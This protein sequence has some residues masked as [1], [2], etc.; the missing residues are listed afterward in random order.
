[1]LDPTILAVTH[2]EAFLELLR[3]HLRECVG[4][5]ARL[6]VAKTI[7]DACSLLS[8]AQPRVI[9]LHWNR[10]GSHYEQ[11]DRL[12]WSTSVQARRIATV[13]IAERYRTEQATMM[14]R[15]G[16]SEYI[17]R[18]HHV[19]QIGQV[20]AAYIRP[21]TQSV[22]APVADIKSGARRAAKRDK[23]ERV[24]TAV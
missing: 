4:A 22:G 18:T 24:A 21:A 23:S 10:E 6:V 13:V 14:F 8:T 3:S 15:M 12:L 7:D 17:S 1:M 20:F 2:D 9:I 16:V 5:G 11:L 19:A